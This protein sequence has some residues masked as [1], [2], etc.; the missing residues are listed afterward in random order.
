MK[1]GNKHIC[2][3]VGGQP[4]RV[5]SAYLQPTPTFAGDKPT[6]GSAGCPWLIQMH[7]GQK[8]NLTL[9]SF[10]LVLD[11]IDA[12]LASDATARPLTPPVRCSSQRIVIQEKNRTL[13]LALC[14]EKHR[15]RHIFT[16]DGNFISLYVHQGFHHQVQEPSVTV[17]LYLIKYQ[18][19]IYSYSLLILFRFVGSDTRLIC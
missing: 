4:L 10:H 7:P 9:L 14:G 3:L 19:N 8:I 5:E 13:E 15:E 12:G 1:S 11:G 16:S 6:V 17:G 2:G 18:G